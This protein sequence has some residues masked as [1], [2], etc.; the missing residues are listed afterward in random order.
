[1][2]A[3]IR[4]WDTFKKKTYYNVLNLVL[5]ASFIICFLF[6]KWMT[7]STIMKHIYIHSHATFD[8]V[9]E[10]LYRTTPVVTRG[11]GFSGLIRR[12]A[13][14]SRLLRHARICWESILTR[15]H[16]APIQSP[17]TT[18]KGMW[19]AYSNWILTIW[20]RY[21]VQFLIIEHSWRLKDK[22]KVIEISGLKGYFW[23]N[24]N[25]LTKMLV[26]GPRADDSKHLV[27]LI[28]NQHT[29][30]KIPQCHT[31][32]LHFRTVSFTPSFF[33]YWFYND[34]LQSQILS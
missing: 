3:T 16:T 5:H 14:F 15:I 12:T 26:S 30:L 13:Q 23:K 1:M 11:L 4:D 34:R 9:Y 31:S 6:C 32:N 19:K 28:A 33:V 8:H 27:G 10:W 18:D 21:L 7:L 17:L 25:V 2:V 20:L 24:R 22:S 29:P